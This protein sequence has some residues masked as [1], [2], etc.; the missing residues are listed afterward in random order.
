MKIS[1]SSISYVAVL[2]TCTDGWRVTFADSPDPICSPPTKLNLPC[3]SAWSESCGRCSQISSPWP[4]G[5]WRWTRRCWRDRPEWTVHLT[6][7][8]TLNAFTGSWP[9]T[10]RWVN[11]TSLPLQ[12][13]LQVSDLL[14]DALL[15]HVLAQ[16]EGA[17]G[18]QSE[19]SLSLP[20]FT[21]AHEETSWM[22][23]HTNEKVP[24]VN[25]TCVMCEK[26][27]EMLH[28]QAQ[29]RT[30]QPQRCTADP[31]SSRPESLS[32]PSLSCSPTRSPWY[33]CRSERWRRSHNVQP[34]VDSRTKETQP[35]SHE[36]DKRMNEHKQTT[37]GE[38]AFPAKIQHEW[39][40]LEA[41]GNAN[42]HLKYE[43]EK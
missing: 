11:T 40:L 43:A 28:L 36:Q 24:H 13:L 41:S 39:L 15:Q 4:A 34:A 32:F 17:Q 30:C 19:P 33:L 21:I 8:E 12:F 3:A 20:L 35:T 26:P 9:I 18:G 37:T 5:K 14:A 27:E 6:E 25:R 7:S 42:A 1:P 23:E 10:S 16:A 29:S 38:T 2:K 22:W 31:Q